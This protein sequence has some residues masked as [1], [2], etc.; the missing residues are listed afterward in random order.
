MKPRLT[1]TVY[2]VDD[3]REIRRSL[4]FMLSADEIQSYPFASG[5]DFLDA[6]GDLKPGCVLLD[7]R[8]PEMDGFEVM[9]AMAKRFVDWPVIVMTGH[10]DIPIAVRAIKQGA[11]DF[12]EKPFSED[13]LQVSL[14]NGL[15]LLEEREAQ[16]NRRRNAHERVEALTV[17]ER[18]VLRELLG[19][20]SNKQIAKNLEISLRTVEMHRGNM[21]DRLQV[22]SLAE[23]L[24]MA[25]EAGLEAVPA[26][27]Q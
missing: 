13:K 26:K 6:L 12:V 7:L 11:V 25:L 16:G 23:A 20:H 5:A 3:D 22:G 17:R 9:A 2:V 14:N 21:M 10:G 15:V 18:E 8:M 24:T 27:V 4:S 1:Q 19:G